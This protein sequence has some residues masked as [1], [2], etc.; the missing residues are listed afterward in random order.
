MAA[1]LTPTGIATPPRGVDRP[2]VR[3]PADR[4]F[5]PPSVPPTAPAPVPADRKAG[6]SL[7]R[8]MLPSLSHALR[9]GVAWGAVV[10]VALSIWVLASMDG[11]AYY[12]TPV[13]VRGYVAAHAVLRPSA[14]MGQMFGVIGTLLML[15]PFLYMARKRTRGK[16]VGTARAWLEVHLFCGIVGP[17]LV[18]FHTAFK[19]NGFVSAAYWSMMAV[20]LSGFVGRYLYVRIPR[21][22]RGTELTRADLDA[23]ADKLHMELLTTAGGGVILDKIGRLEQAAAPAD[24]RLSWIGL[25]FGEIGVRRKLH[26]LAEDVR[27]STL[28][29]GQQDVLMHIASERVLLLRRV[30]YLQRT[31]SAFG[32]WHV[33]HLPLVYLMLAV[34]VLHVGVVLYMGYVPFRW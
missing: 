17:V 31:K 22:I 27:R 32:L 1:T 30:A 12:L 8:R 9:S 16:G 28:T 34:T 23:W 20:M 5:R 26:A 19:F 3:V 6:Q 14:P 21:S 7:L 33:F 15:V 13:K 4:K 25:L 2:A 10:S 24:T 18:T 29:R 11:F